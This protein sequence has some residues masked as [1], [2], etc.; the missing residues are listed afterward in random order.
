MFLR[1]K[2][3]GDPVPVS[4]KTFP[5]D[6]Y[7]CYPRFRTSGI[8]V[9]AKHKVTRHRAPILPFCRVLPLWGREAVLS[10]EPD[11]QP[12]TGTSFQ[13]IWEILV[14]L[15]MKSELKG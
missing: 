7:H 2:G 9:T 15:I 10:V 4:P 12:T 3:K 14:S 11:L 5:V 13:K 1:T 6:E 8:I